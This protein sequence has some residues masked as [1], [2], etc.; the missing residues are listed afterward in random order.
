LGDALRLIIEARI[1]GA[2]AAS[3]PIK[4]GVCWSQQ[5]PLD[6]MAAYP[7]KATI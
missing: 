2:T 3:T 7:G 6:M 5:E 4:L 1:K